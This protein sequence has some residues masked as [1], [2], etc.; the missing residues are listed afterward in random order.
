VGPNKE[1]VIETV[2][3]VDW[4]AEIEFIYQGETKGLAH[5]ILIA[6]E[7]LD[8][9][10]F[11]MYLGDNIL[12]NGIVEHMEKFKALSPNSLILL[13]EVENPQQFGV[14]ELDSSGRVKKLVEKPRIPPS[15][16]ALVGIYFFEPVIIEACKSIKPSWRNELEITDAIQ[17]LVENGYRV[18]ASIVKGWWKDTGKPE[19]ILEANRLV[20]DEI[21]PRVEGVVDDSSKIMGRVVV[22]ANTKIKNSTIKGPSI[23]GKNCTISNSYIGPYTSIGNSCEIIETEI[24]DSIV[25][26]NSKITSVKGIVES[27]IGKNVKIYEHS[28]RPKG[29]R[30][31]VGDTSNIVL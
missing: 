31:I 25:M 20:L 11:V 18:E 30:F 26:E 12:K 3:S 2:N 1:Q 13:T 6:E 10:S 28:M 17:W 23:I 24:E 9:E 21:S 19:D 27:L 8:D 22:G 4:G 7:F 15:N 29:Y 5:A 16:Y 14:A